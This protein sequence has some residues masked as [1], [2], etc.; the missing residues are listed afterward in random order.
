MKKQNDYSVQLMKASI[1]DVKLANSSLESHIEKA[2]EDKEKSLYDTKQQY[3]ADINNL[4]NKKLEE[5]NQL[6]NDFKKDIEQYNILFQ[7]LELAFEDL[8][9]YSSKEK[10]SK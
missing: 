2:I 8:L 7:G 3:L 5:K 1:E 9:S 10:S 4:Q 6:E